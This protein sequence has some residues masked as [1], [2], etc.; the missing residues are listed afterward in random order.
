MINPTTH[1][2]AEFP[3]PTAGSHPVGI[4]RGPDGNLWFTENA[5]NQIGRLTLTSSGLTITPTSSLPLITRP[6]TIDGTTQPGFAGTPIIELDGA[7]AGTGVNGLTIEDS[8]AGSTV[9]GL[10]IDRFNGNGIELD[11]GGNSIV[12]NF[13]GTDVTGTIALGNGVSGLSV[14][15]SNNTIGG[16]SP[17]AR[18]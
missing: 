7:S 5:G 2:I 9:R 17:A 18:T 16:T 11:A 10:V 1:V 14:F 6:V 3:V 8:G 13:I 4:T 12:G 15:S